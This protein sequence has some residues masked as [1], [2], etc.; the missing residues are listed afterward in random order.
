MSEVKNSSPHKKHRGEPLRVVMPVPSLF[1]E[2]DVPKTSNDYINQKGFPMNTAEKQYHDY[3][4][5]IQ[6]FKKRKPDY[7][8]TLRAEGQAMWLGFNTETWTNLLHD[9]TDQIVHQFYLRNSKEN[10]SVPIIGCLEDTG[11]WHA[12]LMLWKDDTKRHMDDNE[13]MRKRLRKAFSDAVKN[14]TDYAQRFGTHR[15]FRSQKIAAEAANKINRGKSKAFHITRVQ[16]A[17]FGGLETY[18]SKD[19]WLS[20]DEPERFFANKYA[21]KIVNE[22]RFGQ[23]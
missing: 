11:G 1:P 3:L 22:R 4:T 19:L 18:I 13:Q 2:D 6:D 20:S 21:N 10:A 14:Q 16:E 17:M 5:T 8:V 23:F 9:F 12:H 15:G 7:F